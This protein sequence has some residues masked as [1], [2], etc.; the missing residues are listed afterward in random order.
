MSPKQGAKSG[1]NAIVALMPWIVPVS[2]DAPWEGSN[3][4]IKQIRFY[5]NT[6]AALNRT[7]SQ[8]RDILFFLHLLFIY[9]PHTP[10]GKYF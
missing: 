7:P 1:M 5:V 6:K 9:E 2:V 4:P 8:M 3:R 10:S